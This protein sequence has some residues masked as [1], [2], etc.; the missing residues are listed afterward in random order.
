[1]M[2]TMRR[3]DIDPKLETT[4]V[5]TASVEERKDGVQT[6]RIWRLDLACGHTRFRPMNVRTAPKQ[7]PCITCGQDTVRTGG[8]AKGKA[9]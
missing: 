4:R 8:K 5:V 2:A 9:K 1:M 3:N 6:I 7:I